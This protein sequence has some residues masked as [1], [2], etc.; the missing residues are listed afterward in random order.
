MRAPE[1]WSDRSSLL[2]ALLSPLGWGYHFGGVV[3]RANTTS[4]RAPLPVIC[5]GNLTAGGTGKTPVALA[6]AEK[7]KAAGKSPHFLTR[8]YGGSVSGPVA[9]DM[10]KH[11]A[12]DVGDEAL[13]L[14]ASAPTWVSADRVKG[15]MAAAEAGAELIVMDD[16]FQNPS[17]HKDVSLLV[18]DGGAGFGNGQLIPAG[19]LRETISGGLERACGVIM[20]GEDRMDVSSRLG[21]KQTV[22]AWFKPGE[23]AEQ[24]KAQKV[25]AFAGIGRPEKFYQTL[26]EVGCDVAETYDFADHHAFSQEEVKA[27]ITRAETLNARPVTTAKDAVRLP[28]DLKDKIAV[29]TISL[30]WENEEVLDNLLKDLTA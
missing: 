20:V 4:W 25:V 6:I 22:Q 19:P 1:F 18:I 24:F 3:R 27:I 30:Q 15:A 28:D 17:L 8:G 29:L 13:L 9:V 12:T 14:A 10:A 26:R 2:A 21:S 5:I 16:G 23:E 11:T 7:L